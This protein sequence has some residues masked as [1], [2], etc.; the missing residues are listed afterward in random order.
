MIKCNVTING[1]VSL[2]ATVRTNSE[3]QTFIC[4][5]VK[6]TIPAKSGAGNKWKS[7]C[8]R[9]EEKQMPPN[10]PWVQGWKCKAHSLSVSVAT[11]FT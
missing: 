9:T 11:T 1:T 2:T 8:Q 4:F 6:A 5:A 7:P 3:G 10:M